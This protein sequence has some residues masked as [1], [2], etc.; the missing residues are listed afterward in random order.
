MGREVVRIW[1]AKGNGQGIRRL[2]PLR[3]LLLVVT[4][5]LVGIGRF[6]IVFRPW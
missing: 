4:V 5:R 1:E 3:G 2:R 6:D